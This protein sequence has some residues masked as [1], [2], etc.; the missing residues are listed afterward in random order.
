MHHESDVTLK[1]GF[2]EYRVIGH[3]GQM[4][5]KILVNA[6]SGDREPR[7]GLDADLF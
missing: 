7:N 1:V 3:I 2:S 4:H 6:C 5:I